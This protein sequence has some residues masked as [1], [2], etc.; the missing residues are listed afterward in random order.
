MNVSGKLI[1]IKSFCG[2][3][4]LLKEDQK[5]CYLTLTLIGLMWVVMCKVNSCCSTLFGTSY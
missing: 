4:F 3:R 5:G 2:T 1:V